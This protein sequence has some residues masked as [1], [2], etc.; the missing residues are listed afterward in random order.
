M[1]ALA[2][3]E[4]SDGAGRSARRL[5]V[6]LLLVVAATF[7]VTVPLMQGAA[8]PVARAAFELTD[9]RLTAMKV[10]GTA[11]TAVTLFAAGRATDVYGA[12]PVLRVALGVFAAGLAAQ[13][14]AFS[15]WWYL[16]GLAAVTVGVAAVFVVCL[17]SVAALT[18]PGRMTRALGG[19]LAAMA[20]AF[21]A[22]ANLVPHTPSATAL[23]ATAALAA[24]VVLALLPLAGRLPAAAAAA[25]PVRLDRL[26][27]AG[28][29]GVA[30]AAVSAL[31]VAPVWGWA[32]PRTVA[33]LAAGAVGLA[34]TLHRYRSAGSGSR[35]AMVSLPLRVSSMALATGL[36]VGFTQ[37]ALTLAV[38]V[39]AARPG[40]GPVF[41]ALVLSAFGLGGFVG[42]LLVRQRRIAPLTGCSLGLPLAALGLVL[43]QVL[44]GAPVAALAL[45]CAASALTGLG[46]M[47]AQVPQMSMFLA[48]LPR[49]RLGASAAFHPVS[50]LIGTAA[51]QALPAT[52]AV[53][54]GAGP[55]DARE[56]LWVATAVVGAAAL[57]AG[58]PV[59][60]LGVAVAAGGEYL[61]MVAVAGRGDAHRPGT[62]VAAL[63]VGA[64]S[65]LVLWTRRQQA[66]RLARSRAS[67]AALQRAVLHPVPEQVGALRLAARYRPADVG[68]AVGG[69]F[70][71]AVHTPYGTR[72]LLGDVRGKGLEAVRTVTDLLGCFRSQAHET[73]D[74]AELAARLDRQAARTAQARGDEELF[75]TAL[76]LQHAPDE[77]AVEVVNCGHLAPLQLGRAAP[78]TAQVPARLPLGYGAFGTGELTPVRLPLEPGG[79]LLL[80]TDGLTEARNG[81]GEFYP[82]LERLTTRRLDGP[83]ELVGF[84]ERDVVDWA[85]RLSD[86]MALI[87]LTA[88]EID[89]MS[90]SF[91]QSRV[92]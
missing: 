75:A 8:T 57:V 42:A 80:H 65:G 34:L 82:L 62:I 81:T 2:V 19:W 33:L 59:V 92:D 31:L 35:S 26:F 1:S 49:A 18:T 54:T 44:P 41:V 78:V 29:A 25:Q 10:L 48:A 14:L 32:D 39:L 73:A 89:C 50:I 11:A 83:E 79:A 72:I 20:L 85:D 91:H 61:L 13:A 86:D 58:L 67:A 76:L 90:V 77:D 51:A 16:L 84:L 88:A 63:A 53:S 28:G 36:A 3:S 38:P 46:V 22:G 47:L 69:D 27:L 68:C 43:F 23:R 6:P 55:A 24:V 71:E 30:S 40:Q 45:G 15:A 5:P 9:G 7:Y 4:R 56:L 74:L 66:E 64:V 12:R 87:A 70:L 21:F 52:S 37:V 17:S 60:A